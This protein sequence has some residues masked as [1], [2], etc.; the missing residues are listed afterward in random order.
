MI[1]SVFEIVWAEPALSKRL[2]LLA[3]EGS[4]P[5]IWELDMRLLRAGLIRQLGRGSRTRVEIRAPVFGEM[6]HASG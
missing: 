6:A 2:E 1:R 5:E 3:K 4:Q